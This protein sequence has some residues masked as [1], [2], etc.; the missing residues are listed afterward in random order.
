MKSIRLSLMVYFLA[1]LAAALAA[2]SVLVYQTAHQ[3]LLAKKEAT[4]QLLEA[5]YKERCEKERAK[6]DEN[7]LVQARTVARLAQFQ[8]PAR[9]RYRE[10]YAELGY[11]AAPAGPGPSFGLLPW[12]AE[13]THHGP[14]AWQMFI[15]L[16]PS[17]EIT[18]DESDLHQEG[19]GQV[20]EYFQVNSIWGSSYH[21]PS[22]GNRALPFDANQFAQDQVLN[23][24]FDDVRLRPD[25]IVR[26]VMLRAPA[27]RLVPFVNP[28]PRHGRPSPGGPTEFPPH[29]ALVIHSAA[30]KAAL[31][32]TLAGFRGERDAALAGLDSETDESLVMLRNRLLA[33]SLI[34][35]AAIAVGG[36]CLV[37]VGLAPLRRLS[38]AVSQV[39]EKDFRLP[40]DGQRLPCELTAIVERLTQTLTLLE[41]AFAHEKQAAADISHELRTPLA[42][43]LTTIDVA[44]RRPRS[45]EEYRELLEECRTSGRQ[46][47][48]LVERLL[49]LARLDAG[50]DRVRPQTVDAA[51]LAEQCA[52]LV[53][54]LAEARGLR[55][56]VHN[57]GSAELKADPD[58]LREV[59]TNLLHNAI[60]YNR[61]QGSVDLAVGKNNG[62]LCLEVRDTGIGIAPEAQ[63][64]LFERFYRADP[65]R[66][67]E[68]MHAGLGLA[69]VKG[70]VDLMG[71]KI[72]VESTEGQGSTFR[73]ELPV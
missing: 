1:L 49:I 54:P 23:W 41:R 36:F 4:R 42:A 10:L 45:P 48:R 7:L 27:A 53:R 20:P 17:A 12:F 52:A 30:D 15:K 50:V 26:R 24:D 22:L 39:S 32:A 31:D 63:V 25:L 14:I 70:Y 37:R 6:L 60:E 8:F 68:G 38:H 33:I 71:G 13:G 62:H 11:L 59:L 9:I 61:P 47:S 46:M 3:T 58:K 65:A 57:G 28:H 18:F 16:A 64:H 43:L 29:P 5:Q 51:D 67:S 73:V 69:I 40:F 66:Q 21:S 55:L 2:V 19:E 56:H 72:A 34:T 44:L 35:F